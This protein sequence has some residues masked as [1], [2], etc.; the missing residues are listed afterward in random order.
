MRLDSVRIKSWRDLVEAFLK[1]YK[2]NMEIAPDRTS[3]MS[4]EKRSQESVR[5]YAQRWRDEAMHVQPPL[6]ETEMV[7]LFANT[8][9]APYY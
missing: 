8:F 5:A 1:Q 2:F 4:M 9:K 6:I 3:L 7:T